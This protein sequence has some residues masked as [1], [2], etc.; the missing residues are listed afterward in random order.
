MK[1]ELVSSNTSFVQAPH[2]VTSQKAPFFTVS[3]VLEN[4]SDPGRDKKR[5]E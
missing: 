5:A 4:I 2:G 1:E 3:K